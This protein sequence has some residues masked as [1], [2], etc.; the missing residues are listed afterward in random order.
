MDIEQLVRWLVKND[1]NFEI[2]Q[3]VRAK[4]VS[5]SIVTVE[6]IINDDEM[7]RFVYSIHME[8]LHIDY[9]YHEEIA[10]YGNFIDLPIISILSRRTR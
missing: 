1:I 10:T 7:L 8:L 4:D 9:E 6:L 5:S 2:S 3:S